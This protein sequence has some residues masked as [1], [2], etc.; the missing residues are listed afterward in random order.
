MKSGTE[1]GLML[2][3]A[4]IPVQLGD[5]IVCYK[6]LQVQKKVDWDPGF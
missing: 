4:S 1:C 5:I 6:P 2:N 3:D